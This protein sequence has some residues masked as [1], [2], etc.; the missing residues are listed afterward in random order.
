M[1]QK[2]K[3]CHMTSVHPVRDVRIFHKMC[4]SSAAAG[5]DT[6]LV[7]PGKSFEEKGVK[8]IGAGEKPKS[9][10]KRMTVMAKRVYKKALEIDADIY[11]FHDPELLP[12]GLKLKRKGK[13]VIFDSHE[14]YT[15]MLAD[16]AWIP[17][18]LRKPVAWIFNK[19]HNYTC[20]KLDGV[21][22]VS[23]NVCEKFHAWNIT[24]HMICNFPV[25]SKEERYISPSFNNRNICFAGGINYQWSHGE[26]LYALEK[27][28]DTIY[29]LCGIGGD[30]YINQL[31]NISSW[32]QVEFLGKISHE[33][34]TNF[35][36]ECNIGM[37]IL[38]PS[39]NTGNKFGTLG[40]TKLFEYML[41]GLPVIC[42][43][44]I[45]WRQII[46][47]YN[48]GICVDPENIDEIADAI[49]YLLDNPEIAKRMGENGRKAVTQKYN[50]SIEEKKLLAL[51]DSL[52]K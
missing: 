41:A 26:I 38:K 35:L 49:T 42:T 46:D 31:K 29:R 44:F 5:Y 30:N 32:K 3:V 16:K 13:R 4:V 40:N 50:W 12:Y 17:I 9:R 21:I 8:V 25:A 10:L 48:C 14:D 47:E 43:N 7:A 6:Y 51:Y 19:Y 39:G 24:N 52:L 45:L 33:E 27:T 15:S 2:V 34:I 36:A 11:Q 18:L 1:G 28:P 20:S 37:T 22:C 23:P